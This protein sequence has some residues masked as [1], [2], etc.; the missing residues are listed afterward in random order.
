M[1]FYTTSIVYMTSKIASTDN[2]FSAQD[3]ETHKKYYEINGNNILVYM[4]INK[5]SSTQK[6]KHGIIIWM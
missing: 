2:K 1:F 6:E 3:K 4:L 5:E